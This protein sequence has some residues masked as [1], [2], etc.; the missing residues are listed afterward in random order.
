MT[1]EELYG[2]VVGRL[3]V[4]GLHPLHR[5]IMEECCEKVLQGNPEIA[6]EETLIYAVNMA[7]LTGLSTLKATLNSCYSETDVD[8]ITI[9]YRGQTFKIPKDSNIL[10]SNDSIEEST[11]A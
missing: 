10:K 11:T 1:E 8:L 6:D 5:A 4:T 7:F 9:N 2:S 3:S